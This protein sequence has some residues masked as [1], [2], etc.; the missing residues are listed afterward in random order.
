MAG[1]FYRLGSVVS[2]YSTGVL[3]SNEGET[4]VEYW[5]VDRSGNREATRTASFRI[6]MTPPVSNSAWLPV[7]EQTARI[8]VN[9][10]DTLS[11]VAALSWSIDGVKQADVVGPAAAGQFTTKLSVSVPG[12]HT[13]TYA[14]VDLAGNHEAEK[15]VGPFHVRGDTSIELE[16]ES[17]TRKNT[18]LPINA[19]VAG[20]LLSDDAG[21]GGKPVILEYSASSKFTKPESLSATT[22]HNGS[23][24]FKVS[25]SS[26]TY[27]RVRFAADEDYGSSLSTAV[28]Y[29]PRAVL[30][31]RVALSAASRRRARKESEC[32]SSGRPKPVASAKDTSGRPSLQRGATPHTRSAS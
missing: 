2:T 13:V 22:E 1:T 14:L 32:T 4:V 5:S 18:V 16:S 12:T 20:K 10:S 8:T 9:A 29:K 7:N 24:N 21:I 31:M 17:V 25:L 23:F 28:W 19:L 11:G 3:V 27:Y 30:T 6:D 15:T 26:R